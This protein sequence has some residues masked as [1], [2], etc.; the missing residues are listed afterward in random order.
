MIE[1]PEP[2]VVRAMLAGIAL[3]VIAAPLGCLVV[4]RRMAYVGETL[5]QSSLLGVALGLALN[6][7]LTISVIVAAVAAAGV[8]IAF[9]R[10]KLLALDSV[11]GLMHHAALA[12]GVIAIALLKGPSIDLMGYLFGDV[13]AVTEA[14]LVTIGL[15]GSVVLAV[16]LWLWRPLVRQSL[17][18]DLATAEGVSP[19]L[20]RALFD[21]LLAVTI[22]VS[23][24]IV[25]ILLVM[26][27]LIVPA[28]AARP[29][30][31]TPERMA[32]LAAIIAAVSVIAGLTLS[33]N[34]DAPGGPSIVL[35]MCAFAVIS[36][37]AAGRRAG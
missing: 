28:V 18:E 26:A 34:V 11:L 12:L 33:L 37:L 31:S 36:L 21:I 9:G 6:I 13:F 35:A 7:D 19:R 29:L 15:G 17:H 16:T 24:K 27:F 25:G 14:D 4:W 20:P 23:M 8:L 10:Q 5:A 2:F 32:I 30:A 22:A 3:A 1:W